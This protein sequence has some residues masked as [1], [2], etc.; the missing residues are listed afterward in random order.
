MMKHTLYVVQKVVNLLN[1]QQTPVICM[2]QPLYAL[3]KQIQWKWPQLYGEDK[4][5]IM[6]GPLHIE[7]G[8]LRLIGEWLDQSGWTDALVQANVTSAG[9]A[10]SYVKASHV[11]RTRRAHEVTVCA[12]YKLLGTAYDQYVQELSSDDQL[13]GN[14]E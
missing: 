4:F 14:E 9:I 2:D 6:F 13:L 12:L 5:V 8:A 1:P 11:G 7:M 3:T 10:D